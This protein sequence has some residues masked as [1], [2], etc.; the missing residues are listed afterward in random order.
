MSAGRP[1]LVVVYDRNSTAPLEVAE[2]ARPVCDLVWVLDLADP[3]LVGLAPLIRRLGTI[4]DRAGLGD[5]EVVALLEPQR[6]DGVMTFAERQLPL[7]AAIATE[8]GLRF[9]GSETAALLCNKYLQRLALARAGVAGPDFWPLAAGADAAEREELASRLRYPVVL[10]PQEGLGS[11]Q[12]LAVLDAGGL[13][14]ALQDAGLE[15]ADMLLE[16]L[17]PESRPRAQ[18][19]FGETLMVDSLACDGHVTHYA[20]T[21][22]FIPAPPF[23]GTGSFMPIHLGEADRRAVVEQTDAALAAL[24]IESGFTNTDLILTPA[25]PRVLEVNGRI[26]GDVATLLELSAGAP[27]LRE[28]M[29]FATG[30]TDV[31]L[32]AIE[33]GKVAFSVNHQPPQDARRLLALDGLDEIAALPGV[34]SVVRRRGVGDP[35]D[36]R[37]GTMSRLFTVYGAVGDHDQLHELHTRIGRCVVADY[38]LDPRPADRDA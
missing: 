28:A 38:E 6:P 33:L 36:W 4:I 32:A 8:F 24:G 34:S 25:G 3:V 13:L 29:R 17:L 15:V 18:Q 27:L 1:K 23:R 21:G 26:G 20:I 16:E 14:A 37:D 11:R 22:H 9:H 2:A 10:K 30:A 7:A 19:R 5:R 31:D 35:L 12:T